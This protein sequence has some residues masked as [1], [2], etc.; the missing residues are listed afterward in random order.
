MRSTDVRSMH[1]ARR[2]SARAAPPSSRSDRRATTAPGCSLL[3]RLQRRR[4][5]YRVRWSQGGRDHER[6][7][8][9]GRGADRTLVSDT[10]YR[11]SDAGAAD[12]YA[13]LNP[14]AAA[15]PSRNRISPTSAFTIRGALKRTTAMA[16]K[17]SSGSSLICAAAHDR[18]RP[19]PSERI[20]RREARSARLLLCRPSGHLAVT[21]ASVGHSLGAAVDER[22]GQAADMAACS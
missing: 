22:P 5:Q 1:A 15:A 18:N 2:A 10:R 20:G 16:T 14:S 11:G 8:G 19:N 21:S 4:H 7:G 3:R 12:A 13:I 17:H 6:A 9:C